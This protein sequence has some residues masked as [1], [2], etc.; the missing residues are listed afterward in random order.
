M[1]KVFSV[2]G[3]D[4]TMASGFYMWNTWCEYRKDVKVSHPSIEPDC[5]SFLLKKSMV[6][7]GKLPYDPQLENQK[8]FKNIS[9]IS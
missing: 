4:A 8:Y 1:R 5:V 3:I 6:D 2:L 7:N 9:L